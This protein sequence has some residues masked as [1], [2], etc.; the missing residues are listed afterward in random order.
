MQEATTSILIL[1]PYF[2]KWPFWMPL[3]LK[4]C[5]YNPDVNWL[6]IGD[7]G[8]PEGLPG[9]VNYQYSSFADYC[10]RVS[11]RLE[12][13]FHPDNPYKLCDLK[14]A[15]GFLHEKDIQGYDFW[16]FGDLDLVYGSLRQ[17]YT[18]EM[19]KKYD[20]ISN[21]ATRISGHLCLLR[22]T[23]RMCIAFK[24]IPNWK[25]ALQNPQHLAVDE[26][27]FSRLFVKHKNFPQWLRRLTNQLYPMVR[28]SSCVERYTTPNG[29]IPWKDGTNN[30]PTEWC[31]E[32]GKIWNNLESDPE[33][34]YPYFHFL[35]WKREFDRVEM[36]LPVVKDGF[37][38]RIYES[39]IEIS[40][41]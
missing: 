35:T 38:A 21:H 18:E 26:K 31:W 15:Y 11:T 25:S 29:Y 7:C 37:K 32:R 16:G 40:L 27:A 5:E 14:P 1:M 2:G 39:G 23:E 9:N 28:K 33:T 22:N 10:E 4:S 19:L 24:K 20:L 34:P 36:G 8:E 6:L 13:D 17:V 30:Y 12:L 41:N 3:F